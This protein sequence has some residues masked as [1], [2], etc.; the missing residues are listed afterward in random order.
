MKRSR[1]NR[2]YLR[3]RENQK[4]SE[5]STYISY[6]DAVPFTGEIWQGGGKVQAEIYGEKLSYVRNIRVDGRYV[7]TTDRSGI[8]HYVYADGLDIVES[9]GLCLYVGAESGPDYKVNAIKPHRQLVLE[10]LKL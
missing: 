3:S 9:D 5:G 7:I 8:T 10:A 1:K 2:F 6:A 4:D